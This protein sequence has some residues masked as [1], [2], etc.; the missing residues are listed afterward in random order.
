MA[1]DKKKQET[2]KTEQKKNTFGKPATKPKK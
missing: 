1:D 2:K